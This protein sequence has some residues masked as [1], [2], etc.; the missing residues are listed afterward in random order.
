[1]FSFKWS[2]DYGT[3]K[4]IY[5][6]DNW[7]QL[8]QCAAAIAHLYE[9]DDNVNIDNWYFNSYVTPI[10]LVRRV[11]YKGYTSKSK[12][13]ICVNDE[14]FGCS[15]TTIAQTN[16]FLDYIGA[17]F[18][19]GYRYSDIKA[20]LKRLKSSNRNYEYINGK[21]TPMI[22]ACSDSSMTKAFKTKVGYWSYYSI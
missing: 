6:G 13:T 20:A 21:K 9:S 12:I 11:R 15:K 10:M 17:F 7:R 19:F 3:I 16:K 8:N 1:M 14:Y 2:Y 22:I 4:A 18:I 5:N